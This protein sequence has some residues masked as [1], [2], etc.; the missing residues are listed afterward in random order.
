MNVFKDKTPFPMRSD[1]MAPSVAPL[2]ETDVQVHVMQTMAERRADRADD[3]QGVKNVIRPR[4]GHA[5]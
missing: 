3:A 1:T 4:R 5:Y 2:P